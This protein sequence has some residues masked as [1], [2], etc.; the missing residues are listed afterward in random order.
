MGGVFKGGVCLFLI[1]AL[2]GCRPSIPVGKFGGS[3]TRHSFGITKSEIATLEVSRVGDKR[4]QIL[5]FDGSKQSP[6]SEALFVGVLKVT[7]KEVSFEHSNEE[8]YLKW[9]G[10]CLEGKNTSANKTAELCFSKVSLFIKIQSNSGSPSASQ[11]SHLSAYGYKFRKFDPPSFETAEGITIQE[12]IEQ[13]L[14]SNFESRQA[15]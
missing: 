1:F 2:S 6:L 4:F 5:A 12:G 10:P 8:Y 9:N 3:I 11:Y 7:K 14:T 15:L 13:I